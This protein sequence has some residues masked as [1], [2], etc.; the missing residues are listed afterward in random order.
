MKVIGDAS[1]DSA[2]DPDYKGHV[3]TSVQAT[4]KILS[5]VQTG[6]FMAYR[7]ALNTINNRCT[8]CHTGFRE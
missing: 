2:D 6:D 8:Q 1:Y 4:R 7:Q 5:A 3:E